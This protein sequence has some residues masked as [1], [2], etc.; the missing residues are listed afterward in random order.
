MARTYLLLRA[1]AGIAACALP[2]ASLAGCGGREPEVPVPIKGKLVNAAGRP[3]ANMVLTFHP[4]DE[5]NKG[6]MR[7][8]ATDKDGRFSD[9]CIRGRYKVTLAPIPKKH[10]AAPDA[11]G[12]AAPPTGGGPVL[13]IP[14]AYRSPDSTPLAVEVPEG[15]KEDIT[16]TVR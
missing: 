10:G 14:A 6:N 9:T 15:G 13:S 7:T 3:L 2:C 8:P 5:L 12:I 1:L 11:G 16:L 4:Q